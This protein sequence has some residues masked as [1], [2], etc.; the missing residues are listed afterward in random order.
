MTVLAVLLVLTVIHVAILYKGI[1][2]NMDP[3]DFACTIIL[4]DVLLLL[5]AAIANAYYVNPAD[6]V[7]IAVQ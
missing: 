7:H 6:F 1:K 2:S 5:V 3:M 4:L